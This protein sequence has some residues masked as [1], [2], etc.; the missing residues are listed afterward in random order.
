MK[1]LG[2]LASALI[3]TAVMV[4]CENPAAPEVIE[5][6]QAK[7][8][9]QAEMHA[10]KEAAAAL[11]LRAGNVPDINYISRSNVGYTSNNSG[12]TWNFLSSDVIA[13]SGGSDGKGSYYI[14]SNGEIYQN[15]QVIEWGDFRDVSY[16]AWTDEAFALDVNGDLYEMRGTEWHKD[17][18]KYENQ[19]E[20]KI[21]AM[22]LD[23]YGNPWVVIGGK[24]IYKL[25]SGSWV[26]KH[27]VNPMSAYTS[28]Y[29]IGVGDYDAYVSI[30]VKP[31][32]A[33]FSIPEIRQLKK[34]AEYLTSMPA[35]MYGSRVDVA[36]DG[37]SDRVYF[38]NTS[39]RGFEMYELYRYEAD[40]SITL[41][42]TG[43]RDVGCAIYL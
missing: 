4:G 26:L 33:Q 3:A 38:V 27:K 17:F 42:A 6:T 19:P 37:S 8:K 11:G 25:D 10:E 31:I 16:C 5:E 7:A 41:K 15:G 13:V 12:N 24:E 43:A 14:R 20:G 28:I 18:V 2:L 1:K 32:G 36:S 39:W 21:T 40:G 30:G 29:D 22:D 23:G 34:G 35:T 9:T